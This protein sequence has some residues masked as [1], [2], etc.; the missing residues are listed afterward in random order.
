M[1]FNN[2]IT[3]FSIKTRNHANVFNAVHGQLLE[4]TKE[5]K[6]Q[7]ESLS[8]PYVIQEGSDI[9]ISKRVKGKMYFKVTSR[10]SGGGTNDSVKVSPNMGIKIQE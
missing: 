7:L 5:N 9:P 3:Q 4:N 2:E 10:Q 8:G 1:A 6:M